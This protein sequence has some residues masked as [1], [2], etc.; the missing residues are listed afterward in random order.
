MPIPM[1]T[2]NSAVLQDNRRKNWFWDHNYI[3]DLGLSCYAIVVRL[4]LARCANE[5]RQAWPSLSKIAAHCGISRQTAKR[6][7]NELIEKGLLAKET[8][9]SEAGDYETN[10]YVLLDPNLDSI[11]SGNA[12]K[13]D[14]PA[15]G[16]RLPQDLPCN[17]MTG[18]VGYHRTY[19]GYYRTYVGPVVDS[20]NTQ[21]NNINNVVVVNNIPPQDTKATSE[22]Q[23]PEKEVDSCPQ[24]DLPSPQ[25]EKH[26]VAQR[27]EVDV[28]ATRQ[29]S[30]TA[31]Q[32]QEA[33]TK[34]AGRALD[35]KALGE[36]TSYPLDYVLRKIAM[37]QLGKDK[38]NATGWLLEACRED[39]QH[40][41]V[42]RKRAARRAPSCSKLP[43]SSTDDK[44]RDL[45][46]LV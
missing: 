24:E 25:I 13:Q 41:P 45:Y 22:I 28:G 32:I 37:V 3:F 34:I 9:M 27:G 23:Q 30:E 31:L 12:Q 42:K 19:L 10:V 46:R 26:P 39:Y 20:N 8:R 36:L 35:D 44:Y 15:K 21:Y 11:A 33:F 14:A 18:G 6:A 1:I 29:D 2:E 7:I 5:N 4:Y 40:L 16:G 38:I 43:N 17:E